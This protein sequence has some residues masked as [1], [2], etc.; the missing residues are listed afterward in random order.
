MNDAEILE[1]IEAACD[2]SRAFTIALTEQLKKKTFN[3]GAVR[4]CA[5]LLSDADASEIIGRVPE[6]VK[7]LGEERKKAQGIM[8]SGIYLPRGA[9]K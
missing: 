7:A 3:Y 5:P 8:P 4:A 6:I 1:R 2:E 9:V